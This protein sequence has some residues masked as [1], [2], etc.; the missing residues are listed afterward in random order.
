V[1][2]LP[3]HILV[4]VTL[5]FLLATS[6]GRSQDNNDLAKQAL[7]LLQERCFSCHGEEGA[8]EGGLN[9]ILKPASMMAKEVPE[10]SRE[11][12]L[13]NIEQLLRHGRMM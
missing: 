6:T 3:R 4:L 13:A 2:R 1:K 7:T 11:D 10:R 9:V 5:V 12:I 8:A